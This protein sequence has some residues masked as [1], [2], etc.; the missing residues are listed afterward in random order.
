MERERKNKEKAK[1]A[2]TFWKTLERLKVDYYENY[3]WADICRKA[4][5][6]YATFRTSKS[7]VSIPSAPTVQKL[8]TLF[9]VAPNY[10]LTGFQDK[11]GKRRKVVSDAI[12]SL[13]E[14]TFYL[15]ERML[16]LTPKSEVDSTLKIAPKIYDDAKK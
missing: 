13:D 8:A 1:V 11:L 7:V 10:L 5:I 4:D 9:S 15:V 3:T 6:N 16:G 12:Y 2:R 14:G